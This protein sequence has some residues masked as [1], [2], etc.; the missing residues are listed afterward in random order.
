[1][2]AVETAGSAEPDAVAAALEGL[3]L[4][5]SDGLVGAALD[6]SRDRALAD[7]AV[8]TLVATTQDP[9]V[10]PGGADAPRLFWFAVEESPT[11]G[12]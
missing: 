6:F 8:V 10:R 4:D 5:T 3:T 9:G 7:D 12:E 11:A 1:M 2:R